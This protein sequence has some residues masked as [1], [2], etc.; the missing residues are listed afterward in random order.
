MYAYPKYLRLL[1]GTALLFLAVQM[2]PALNFWNSKAVA[3]SSPSPDVLVPNST[4]QNEA[5]SNLNQLPWLLVAQNRHQAVPIP[6]TAK[7][8]TFLTSNGLTPVSCSKNLVVII[9]INN[10]YVACASPNSNFPPG[11]YNVNLPEI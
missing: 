8:S 11:N 7:V 5:P 4:L 1:S 10:L 2:P 9:S 6:V 3:Q